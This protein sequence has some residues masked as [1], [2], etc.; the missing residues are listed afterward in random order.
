MRPTF[1]YRVIET[2]EVVKLVSFWKKGQG[3]RFARFKTKQGLIQILYKPMVE[4]IEV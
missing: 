3:G 2:E 4:K 1:E